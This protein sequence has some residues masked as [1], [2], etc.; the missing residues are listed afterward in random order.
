MTDGHVQKFLT[1]LLRIVNIKLFRVHLGWNLCRWTIQ[2]FL[3]QEQRNDLHKFL[4][5][6]AG[7]EPKI[8][9]LINEDGQC[10]KLF[11]IYDGEW[12][13]DTH[14]VVDSLLLRIGLYFVLNL[15]CPKQYAVSGI[16]SSNLF[17]A[18]FSYESAYYT[19]CQAEGKLTSVIQCVVCWLTGS[20]W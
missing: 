11:L 18:G 14:A 4:S 17:E 12:V 6:K 15:N 9:A 3:L 16:H 5:P 8:A 20:S 2:V 13:C 7:K 1:S 10:V 19:D